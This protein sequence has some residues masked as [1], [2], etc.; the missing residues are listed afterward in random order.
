MTERRIT[1]DRW[2]DLFSRADIHALGIG[3]S[4]HMIEGTKEVRC[5]D[6]FTGLQGKGTTSQQAYDALRAQLRELDAPMAT[7]HPQVLIDTEGTLCDELIAP[8][9][10][11]VRQHGL[12]CHGSCQGG[13]EGDFA[14]A[15]I[16]FCTA[17]EA[18]EFMLQTAHLLDYQIGDKVA[19]SIHRPL[20]GS[21]PGG[22]AIWHPDYT[23]TL[24]AAWTGT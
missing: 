21:T 18:F 11:A 4:D 3:F 5:T 2:P 15:Y 1:V 13:E 19:M 14:L 20:A 12:A 23:H 17:K 9:V 7:R 10:K 22:K 8:L 16:V 24:V 6:G